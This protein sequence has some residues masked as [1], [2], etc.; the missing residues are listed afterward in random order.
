MRWPL[1]RQIATFFGILMIANGLLISATV[2]VVDVY[3]TDRAMATTSVSSQRAWQKVLAGKDELSPAEFKS[4]LKEIEPLQD[5][6]DSAADAALY[7]MIVVAGAAT[8]ACGYLMLGRLGRGLGS[9]ASAAQRITEGDLTARAVPSGLRSREE[10]QLIRDFNAMAAAL[11]R[12][13]RELAESTASIAHELRTPL[14][15]L[16]GRLHGIADGVFAAE[17]QEVEG[18]IRQVEGLGRLVDDLQTVSLSRSARL[19]LR[20]ERTDLADEANRVL[21]AMSADLQT[22]GLEPVLA[23]QSAPVIAD[24]ARL[25]QVA[26]AV[27]ANACRYAASSG[28]L[29]VATRAEGGT[30]ILE[31]IDNGPGIPPGAEERAFD[32]FWRAEESRNRT[33]GGSGLGLSVVKAIVDAHGGTASISNHA[34]GGA[35]FEMRLPG[36]GHALSAQSRQ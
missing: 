6:V 17:P 35:R 16:R 1:T 29:K 21:V 33:T 11:Q 15:I 5:E 24:G 20:R 3:L 25:R 19:V 22:A 10:D 32:R 34:G 2:R 13:E 4:L 9:V 23:L 7:L 36:A 8:F 18:L 12:A 28:P 14:T 31:I 26:I 30:A 27:L